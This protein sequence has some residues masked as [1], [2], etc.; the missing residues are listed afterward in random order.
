MSQQESFSQPNTRISLDKI[1]Q[2]HGIEL[3]KEGQFTV[4]AY[5]HFYPVCYRDTKGNFAGL[6]VEIM[7]DFAKT[8]ELPIEFVNVE[9][10]DGIW[11]Y[12]RKRL[13]DTAIGGIANSK[14]PD[15][16]YKPRGGEMTEWSIPYFYVHR[17]VLYRPIDPIKQFPADVHGILVGTPG[18]TGWVDAKL[19]LQQAGKP[20]SIMIAGHTDE[21]DIQDL[22]SGRIQGVMRGDL[23]SRAII[24]KER[25]LKM[26]TWNADPRLLADDGEVFAYPCRLGSNIAVSLSVFIAE[27]IDT[28]KL[29]KLL[30]KY[31]LV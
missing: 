27:L 13:A 29:N 31:N 22:L 19:R 5:P 23:V 25:N 21:E 12:P 3:V 26:T 20:T 4:A 15:A 14:M 7:K 30:K 18:S 6:D 9:V 10:F 28:K 1:L 2:H 11:D 8:I 17:S 16:Q 24:K